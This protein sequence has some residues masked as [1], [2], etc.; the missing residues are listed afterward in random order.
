M[1]YDVT[2]EQALHHGEV[3]THLDASIRDV[4]AVTD[5]FLSAIVVQLTKSRK[6]GVSP[7]YPAAVNSGFIRE[8]FSLAF[9]FLRSYGMRF[10][11][12]VLKDSHM[13]SFLMLARM[14]F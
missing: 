3:R 13:T 10:I 11:A 1:P 12:K 7:H 2:P 5:K 6:S 9:Y 8:E 4:K 14:S